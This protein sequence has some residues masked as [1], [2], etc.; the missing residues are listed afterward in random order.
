[1]RKMVYLAFLVGIFLTFTS[2]FCE[3]DQ[4]RSSLKG[5]K[6]INVNI[7]FSDS[8]V[9]LKKFGLTEII[10]ND[11]EVRLRTAGINVVSTNELNKIPGTPQ[12]NI[13]V[14]GYPVS[15]ISTKQEIG[16]AF[17]I[18]VELLQS[19]NLRR[20]PTITVLADTWTKSVIGWTQTD[21]A[22]DIRNGVKTCVDFFINAY[23]T[24]NPKGGE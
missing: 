5:L 4:Y 17:A 11:V 14:A 7:I 6:G 19:T 13:T 20:D 12:L 22:N 1:M 3:E 8:I 18:Q 24:V 9:E 16:L 2:A 23:L 15:T 10:H 21:K